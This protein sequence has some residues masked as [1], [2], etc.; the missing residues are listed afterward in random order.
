[1]AGRM[2]SGVIIGLVVVGGLLNGWWLGVHWIV[3]GLRLDEPAY[4]RETDILLAVG[5]MHVKLT[6]YKCI[7]NKA[8]NR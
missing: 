8:I 5:I 1:M 2:Q 6:V 3:N 7:P 4:R